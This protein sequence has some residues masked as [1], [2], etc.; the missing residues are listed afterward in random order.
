MSSLID[1]SSSH[2]PVFSSFN[3]SGLIELV[4]QF[5]FVVIVVL[6]V[7]GTFYSTHTVTTPVTTT[8]TA[9]VVVPC[10][11]SLTITRAMYGKVNSDVEYLDV[12]ERVSRLVQHD[13]SHDA[14]VLDLSVTRGCERIICGG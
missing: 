2:A 14:D 13:K 5:K 3:S 11:H 1:A 7:V 12:T 6:D 8:H 10:T 9:D 4:H